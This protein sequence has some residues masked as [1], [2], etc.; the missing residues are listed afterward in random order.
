MAW[1]ITT[2]RNS[3]PGGKPKELPDSVWP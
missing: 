1:G 3:L 2:M